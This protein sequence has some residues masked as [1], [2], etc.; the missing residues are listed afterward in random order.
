M[1]VKLTDKQSAAL[2]T[3]TFNP[4]ARGDGMGAYVIH[5][6]HHITRKSLHTKGLMSGHY[7][8]TRE[9]VEML[10]SLAG[11]EVD[12]YG[13]AWEGDIIV[14]AVP[15]VEIQGDDPSMWSPDFSAMGARECY[16]GCGVTPVAVFVD[17]V[18]R[19]EGVCVAHRER[20]EGR[21][22]ELPTVDAVERE[23]DA[24]S[25]CTATTDNPDCL[26]CERV[27]MDAVDMRESVQELKN[28]MEES[29]MELPAIPTVNV[30]QA[31]MGMNG[32]NHYHAPGC[33]DI[34]RES[35][36]HNARKD[37]GVYEFPF[38]SVAAIIEHEYSDCNN[39]DAHDMVSHANDDFDGLKIMACLSLPLGDIQ[40]YPLMFTGGRWMLGDMPLDSERCTVCEVYGNVSENSTDV[41]G[42]HVCGYCVDNGRT[43]AT[44]ETHSL[45]FYVE[46]ERAGIK[47]E[48]TSC[49][50]IDTRANFAEFVCEG[51]ESPIHNAF[52]SDDSDAGF[53]ETDSVDDYAIV[54]RLSTGAGFHTVTDSVSATPETVVSTG[55]TH[56]TMDTDGTQWTR[57]D[58]VLSVGD[59]VKVVGMQGVYEVHCLIPG[60]P[61][62][63]VLGTQG[64]PFPVPAT[65]VYAL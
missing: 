28:A 25:V 10:A 39:G 57:F 44:L 17:Y 15:T 6:L 49:R 29:S 63:Y 53:V 4:N 43:V 65:N 61:V 33:R 22:Y 54:S 51:A 32:M 35:K 27:A 14:K 2:L 37:M 41:D 18:G 47:Y 16:F 26:H 1:N 52:E 8:L 45:T 55:T 46:T 62:V 50:S 59:V 7:Y 9:G 60:L 20:I 34:A 24:E 11:N 56:H 36:R 58:H 19:T 30:V 23:M 21:T 64:E 13:Y 40:G 48:C 12:M 3:A 5:T 38:S 42:K 31:H